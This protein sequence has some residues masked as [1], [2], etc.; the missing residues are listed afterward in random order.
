MIL[1]LS[2]KKKHKEPHKQEPILPDDRTNKQTKRLDRNM[3][4]CYEGFYPGEHSLLCV[5][6]IL[7]LGISI[8]FIILK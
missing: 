4:K 7:K 2:T 8:A 1:V 5:S 6:S 3:L